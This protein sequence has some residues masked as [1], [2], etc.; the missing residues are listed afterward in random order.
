MYRANSV[1]FP[2]LLIL[3]YQAIAA[4][5]TLDTE[6]A[7]R[8]D[9][10]LS[11][12][13]QK[14]DR[15]RDSA[16]DFGLNANWS[17][18]LPPTAGLRLLGS[19]RVTKQTRFEALDNLDLSSG[20]RYRIQP[21]PGYTTPWIELGAAYAVTRY[22][23]SKIRDGNTLSIDLIAGKRFT[24]RLGSQMGVKHERRYGGDSSVFDMQ[25]KQIFLNIDYKL[26]LSAAMYLHLVR[27]YGDQ[28]FTATPDDEYAEYAKAIAI[29]PAFGQRSAYRVDAKANAIEL[30]LNRPINASSTLDLGLR[31]LDVYANEGNYRYRANEFRLAWLYRF[32]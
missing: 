8:F 22:R 13:E 12:A 7:Y 3:P 28:V 29:D 23:D 16:I 9:D 19:M 26:G 14:G 11:R 31:R 5:I 32:Q 15:F 17:T 30:G 1:L 24:D 27:R 20:I 18:L 2:W 25:Q 6:V 21:V 10:N 4:G